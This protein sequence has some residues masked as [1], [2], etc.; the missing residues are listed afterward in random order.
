VSKLEYVRVIMPIG[1]DPDWHAK[2]AVIAEAIMLF[3]AEPRFPAYLPFKPLFNLEQLKQELSEAA[4]IVADLSHER[5]SCYYELALAEAAGAPVVA[6]AE[7]GTPIHQCMTRARV[8]FYGSAE[9][10][11]RLAAAGLA[12]IVTGAPVDQVEVQPAA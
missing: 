10:L 4:A 5:P 3:A 1:S 12:T 11:K 2:Q 8:G 7:A 6:V 9:Q